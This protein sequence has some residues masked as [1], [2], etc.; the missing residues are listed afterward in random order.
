MH[1]SY[2][3]LAVDMLASNDDKNSMVYPG[4]KAGFYFFLK[5]LLLLMQVGTQGEIVIPD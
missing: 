4:L 5:K 2:K 3:I 1:P